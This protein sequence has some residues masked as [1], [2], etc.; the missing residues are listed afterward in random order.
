MVTEK[1]RNILVWFLMLMALSLDQ[2]G[3]FL[4]VSVWKLDFF[5][6]LPVA[7]IISLVFGLA[8]KNLKI[9][10]FM[11]LI[12]F[13]LGGVLSFCFSVIPQLVH[14]GG[15]V[16]GILAEVYIWYMAKLLILSVPASLLGVLVGSLVSGGL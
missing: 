15:E 16:I 8:A 13:I 12:S 9:S 11:I 2:A 6:Y 10:L 4:M 7:L 14:G 1:V 3:G 5:Y